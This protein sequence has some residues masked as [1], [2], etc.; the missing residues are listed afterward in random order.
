[1]RFRVEYTHPAS[2]AVDDATQEVSTGLFVT[3]MGDEVALKYSHPHKPCLFEAWQRQASPPAATQ[4]ALVSGPDQHAQH[5]MSGQVPA[6]DAKPR[7]GSERARQK[8][9]ELAPSL[10]FFVPLRPTCREAACR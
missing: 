4:R 2:L 5:R 1:M 8:P 9:R 6:G 10:F 3:V 7:K